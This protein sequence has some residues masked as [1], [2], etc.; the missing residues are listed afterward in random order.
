MSDNVNTPVTENVVTNPVELAKDAKVVPGKIELTPETPVEPVKK[1]E[2]AAQFAALQK[3]EAKLRAERE[4]LKAEKAQI[5]ASRAKDAQALAE[6]N[7]AKAL[8]AKGDFVEFLN[9]T[10]IDINKLNEQFVKG[11]A[12]KDPVEAAKEAVQ[13]GINKYKEEAKQ[14]EFNKQVQGVKNQIKSH[15]ETNADKYEFL[16]EIPE[17][18]SEVLEAMIETYKQFGKEVTFEEAAKASEEYYE[19]QFKE[20]ASKSK[21]MSSLLNKEKELDNSMDTK[22]I[23]PKV[24]ED[25]VKRVKRTIS[26]NAAPGEAVTKGSKISLSPKEY[27]RQFQENFKKTKGL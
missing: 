6:L 19:N 17:Y 9:F 3:K 13:E 7:Q 20:R 5:E 23:K 11:K 12:P 27:A 24:P 10:G 16:R 25:K 8:L 1:G 14:E 26:P 21:K 15:I 18:E 22:A 2:K 4:A